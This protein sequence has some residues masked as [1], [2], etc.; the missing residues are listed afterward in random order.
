[1]NAHSL[2]NAGYSYYEVTRI[3]DDYNHLRASVDSLTR[4][5]FYQVLGRMGRGRI[6]EGRF[7]VGLMSGD[8]RIDMDANTITY[9]EPKPIIVQKC[10]NGSHTEPYANAEISYP[11]DWLNYTASELDDMLRANPEL[12][13]Q[14]TM[15][16]TNPS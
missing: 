15:I 16:E 10:Q 8:H 11:L 2:V 1:M 4:H 14:V 13:K 7:D 3:I 5:I 12:A 6:C 9:E